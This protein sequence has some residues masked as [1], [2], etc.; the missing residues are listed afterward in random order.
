VLNILLTV[1]LFKFGVCIFTKNI[2]KNYMKNKLEK[3]TLLLLLLFLS[4]LKG[5]SQVQQ[6]IDMSTGIAPGSGLISIGYPDDTWTVALPGAV[7]SF[8]PVKCSKQTYV[9]P[10]GTSSQLYAPNMTNV[11]LLSPVLDA[12]LNTANAAEG[13]YTYKMGFT[14]NSCSKVSASMHFNTIGADN[15]IFS[16]KVNSTTVFSGGMSGIPSD[17]MFNPWVTN[18]TFN[19]P[20]SAILPGANVIEIRVYNQIGVPQ[21][22]YKTPTGLLIDGNLTINYIPNSNLNPVIASSPTNFCEGNSIQFNGSAALGAITA[23][24]WE[25][26][27]CDANWAVKPNGYTYYQWLTGTPSSYTFPNPPC[28]KYYRVKLAVKNNCVA[29]E[30]TAKLIY[31]SCKP[32]IDL[33]GEYNV[34]NGNSTTLCAVVPAGVSV[35]WDFANGLGTFNTYC[36]NVSPQ[37]SSINNSLIL[38][39]TYG[40]I[41]NTTFPLNVI[42]NNPDFSKSTI[43]IAG[44]NYY[45]VKATA[46]DLNTNPGARYE[47]YVE[48]VTETSLGVFVTVPNTL[49]ANPI[50]WGTFINDFNGCIVNNGTLSFN[51]SNTGIGQFPLGKKYRITRATINNYCSWSQI[52]YVVYNSDPYRTANGKEE[53]AFIEDKNAPDMRYVKNSTLSDISITDKQQNISLF[54]NPAATNVTISSSEQVKLVQ[55]TSIN[56]ALLLE[57]ENCK[58]VDMSILPSGMY[59]FNIVTENSRKIIKLIKE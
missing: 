8:V 5:Q 14:H 37:S 21:T 13:I 53:I 24:Y 56:G 31:V 36:A 7:T 16:I 46:V 17:I 41:S 4:I 47:W 58:N 48:E 52:A 39:N 28:D 51:C 40:C 42:V 20:I 44:Q 19:V 26:V 22:L 10:N 57:C 34:C 30:E 18:K 25:M 54:P 23:H 32:T 29:W 12:S 1:I 59:F 43:A 35:K 45:T 33:R 3:I 9:A 11:R 6:I 50:C 2:Y 55:V 49:I 38:T 15:A 27:E